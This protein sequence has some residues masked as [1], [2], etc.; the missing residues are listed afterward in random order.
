MLHGLDDFTISQLDDWTILTILRFHNLTILRYRN[1]CVYLRRETYN[2]DIVCGAA[3][4]FVCT[5]RERAVCAERLDSVRPDGVFELRVRCGMFSDRL[6]SDVGRNV[7]PVR[8]G[9]GSDNAVVRDG[10]GTQNQN[11]K[12]DERKYPP[13]CERY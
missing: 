12:T 3:I 4:L 7:Y 2:S 9:H 5:E 10:R 13:H 8:D 11:Y 1:K 6:L